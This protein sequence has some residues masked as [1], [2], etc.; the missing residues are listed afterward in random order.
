MGSNGIIGQAWQ[1]HQVP[2]IQKMF[3]CPFYFP[4]AFKA[5]KYIIPNLF[6]I[7]ASIM[8]VDSK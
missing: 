5:L 7:A 1:G 6:E 4:Q 3:N 8:N 2:A